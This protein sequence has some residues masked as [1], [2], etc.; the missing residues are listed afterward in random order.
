MQQCMKSDISSTQGNRAAV[1]ACTGTGTRVCWSDAGLGPGRGGGGGDCRE[2][3]PIARW[4]AGTAPGAT[5][6]L[7]QVQVTGSGGR[8][9]TLAML[10]AVG[11]GRC[12]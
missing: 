10:A 4:F 1:P 3:C 5:L 9:V 2:G 6:G 11:A 12:V 8:A 7:W